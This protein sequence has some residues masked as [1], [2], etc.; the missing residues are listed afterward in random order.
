MKVRIDAKV[1]NDPAAL[2]W[3][4]RIQ[5]LFVDEWHLWVA[6]DPEELRSS[7][8]LADPGYTGSSAQELLQ[9]SI[10]RNAYPTLHQKE[11]F[12]RAGAGGD[13][14]TFQ[15]EAAFR[16]L[17]QPLTIL[18]EDRGSDGA[19]FKVILF[20]LGDE[21][22]KAHVFDLA[23]PPWKIDSRG[24]KAKMVEQ[25]HDAFAKRVPPRLFVVRD[26]DRCAP[27]TSKPQDAVE[28]E[29]ICRNAGIGCHVL[30]KRE[31]ENYLPECLLQRRTN[32]GPPM[33]DVFEVWQRL[34]NDQK[35][36]LDLKKGLKPSKEGASLPEDYSALFSG[37]P[38]EDR[39]VL[40]A[41]GFGPKVGAVLWQEAVENP[42][43]LTAQALRARVGGQELDDLLD[44]LRDQL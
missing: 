25:V 38:D 20:T 32:D 29:Q 19:F 3:L 30:E 11:I 28:L 44:D 22:L 16:F 17:E 41:G 5:G 43:L 24:G 9:L 15:V 31:I 33:T 18:V 21:Q 26:S 42:S 23:K 13:A 8:W 12:V 34:D 40:A 10:K 2:Q 35:N 4:V 7:Y 14:R 36:F 37:L 27:S 39:R 1:A 6:D